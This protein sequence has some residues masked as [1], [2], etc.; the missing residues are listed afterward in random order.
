M[1]RP[2]AN[3]SSYCTVLLWE[4]VIRD[5]VFL[6]NKDSLY[7]KTFSEKKTVATM[8]VNVLCQ[9]VKRPGDG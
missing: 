9:N 3:C 2:R 6:K 5:A 4:T 1:S 8:K 7:T